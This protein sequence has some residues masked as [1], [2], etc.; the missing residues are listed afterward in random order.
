MFYAFGYNQYNICNCASDNNKD[1]IHAEVDCMKKLKKCVKKTP[2]NLI[3][4]RTNNTGTSLL[5]SKPCTN[6]MNT[7]NSTLEYKN[8][9]LKKLWY[10]DTNGNFVKYNM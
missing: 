2:I 5:M 4:F 8:Y 6:C 10:T 1:N 7:I 9:K 3:V